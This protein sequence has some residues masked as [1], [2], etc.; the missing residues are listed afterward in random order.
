LVYNEYNIVDNQSLNDVIVENTVYPYTSLYGFSVGSKEERTN[1]EF[2]WEQW[3][4]SEYNIN[5]YFTKDGSNRV[6]VSDSEY[7]QGV[8][9]DNLIILAHAGEQTSYSIASLGDY[10]N[11]TAYNVVYNGTDNTGSADPFVLKPNVY[12]IWGEVDALYLTFED[13]SPGSIITNEYVF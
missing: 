12:Y 1:S 2:T 8:T 9:K 4:D 6:F 10:L 3:I 13:R 5:N 11:K 7:V